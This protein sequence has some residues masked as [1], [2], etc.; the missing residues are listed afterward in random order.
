MSDTGQNI[1]I[2]CNTNFV[3]AKLS[4]K[5]RLH[6]SRKKSHL[7]LQSQCRILTLHGGDRHQRVAAWPQDSKQ[8][9]YRCFKILHVHERLGY[10]QTVIGILINTVE[11]LEVS[12]GCRGPILL[13]NIK[14]GL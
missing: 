9:R 5:Q 10:D 12:N 2:G 13:I 1:A 3:V 14:N 6:P 8:F 11:I 7:I 4:S